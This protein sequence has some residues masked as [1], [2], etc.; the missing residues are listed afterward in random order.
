MNTID[1]IDFEEKLFL[2]K[3]ELKNNI[4]SLMKRHTYNE[5]RWSEE[6][7]Y[8]D[9]NGKMYSIKSAKIIKNDQVILEIKK[10]E[11][12]KDDNSSDTNFYALEQFLYV[13]NID[14]STMI[15]FYNNLYNKITNM[16]LDDDVN[17]SL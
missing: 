9:K 13:L 14:V 8:Y 17:K 15:S 6:Y 11:K 1:Y 4:V 7:S 10:H 12:L 2:L 3:K 16:L 5:L